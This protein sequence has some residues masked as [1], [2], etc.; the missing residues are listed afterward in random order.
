PIVVE[1][2]AVD[3]MSNRAVLFI[4][5]ECGSIYSNVEDLAPRKCTQ[6]ID[7]PLAIKNWFAV[8]HPCSAFN[9]EGLLA[10]DW[11]TILAVRNS[12]TRSKVVQNDTGSIS[13]KHSCFRD[14]RVLWVITVAVDV[15]PPL[16]AWEGVEI[17]CD[18]GRYVPIFQNFQEGLERSGGMT[19]RLARGLSA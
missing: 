14:V 10:L 19:G 18:G 17:Q 13:C 9:H 4:Q 2:G 7:R 15:R 12:L 16:G 11:L 5:V 8:R 1:L 3:G 6:G